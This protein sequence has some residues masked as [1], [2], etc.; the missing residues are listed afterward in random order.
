MKVNW[1]PTLGVEDIVS[2]INKPIIIQNHHTINLLYLTLPK[3][4][5]LFVVLV[6]QFLTYAACD[7][8]SFGTRNI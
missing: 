5:Y 4:Q 2:S 3:L 1:R 7:F 8:K 6:F